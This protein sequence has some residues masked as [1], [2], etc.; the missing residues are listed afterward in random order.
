MANDHHG[1]LRDAVEQKSSWDTKFTTF[2]VPVG[3]HQ[4]RG[5]EKGSEKAE[6]HAG[7]PALAVH[8][9]PH[10]MA[11]LHSNLLSHFRDAS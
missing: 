2:W 4:D 3:R 6:M 1:R 5:R 11:H 7:S 8:T 9:Q 10:I